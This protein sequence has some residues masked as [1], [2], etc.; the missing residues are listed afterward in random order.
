MITKPL[1]RFIAVIS[2][3]LPAAPLKIKKKGMRKWQF[4]L[5]LN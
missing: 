1:L 2:L 5:N 3:F 4:P